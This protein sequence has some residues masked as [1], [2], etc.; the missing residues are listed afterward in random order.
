MQ[1]NSWSKRPV[2]KKL[3]QLA[4]GILLRT[5][6]NR[7]EPKN[8]YYRTNGITCELGSS[9][10]DVYKYLYENHYK[11]VASLLAEGQTPSVD[12]IDASMSYIPGNVRIISL[13]QNIELALENAH[14]K[15]SKKVRITY[16]Q[17]KTYDFKSVR[18]AAKVV[19]L[20]RTTLNEMLKGNRLAG[21]DFTISEIRSDINAS[22]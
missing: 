15:L 3:W 7:N 9:P 22:S 6:P 10:K 8:A 12:R 5:D 14:E 16:N 20:S 19:G 17:G 21:K 13:E 1:R 2:E 4:T 18:E 11:E